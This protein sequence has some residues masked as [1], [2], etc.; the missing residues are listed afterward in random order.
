MS[1]PPIANS[2]VEAMN[3]IGTLPVPMPEIH[4]FPLTRVVDR[5]L[6]QDFYAPFTVPGFVRSRLDGY[7]VRHKDLEK[8]SE[9]N[10]VRLKVMGTAAAGTWPVPEVTQGGCVRIMAGAPVPADATAVVG[11]EQ[12]TLEEAEDGARVSFKAPV[13]EGWAIGRADVGATRGELL[14]GRGERIHPV[15][16][17]RLAGI[18][19]INVPVFSR[20]R[21][22]VLSTGSELL[23]AGMPPS[24]GKIYNSGQT[25]L[26]GLLSAAGAIALPCGIA[27]DDAESIAE[28]MVLALR[29]NTMLVTTGGVG[30]GDF[31]CIRQAMTM[32]GADII[33]G[34]GRFK[35]GGHF[36]LAS[37]KGKYILSLSG[38]PG[39]ALIILHLLGLPLVRRLTCDRNWEVKEVDVILASLPKRTPQGL[40][41]GYLSIER[42]R[43]YFR[44]LTMADVERRPMDLVVPLSGC[45]DLQALIRDETPITAFLCHKCNASS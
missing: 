29:D 38:S 30:Q 18:G 21:V 9:E 10:P 15:N 11:F 43:A 35:P 5:V 14:A 40:L 33:L 42:G 13:N 32:A 28:T 2:L 22:A 25:M 7:A 31:D 27:R 39:S 3:V 16:A 36:A 20:P 19:T 4:T 26:C 44:H 12:V 23:L 17:G 34:G 1:T 41:P 6:A 8:A 24:P 37:L 45:E